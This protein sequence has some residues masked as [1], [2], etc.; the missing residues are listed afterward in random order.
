M[1]HSRGLSLRSLRWAG[2]ELECTREQKPSIPRV[3]LLRNPLPVHS[4][5]PDSVIPYRDCTSKSS[6]RYLCFGGSHVRSKG[7]ERSQDA[8]DC[9]SSSHGARPFPAKSE[10]PPLS[11]ELWTRLLNRPAFFSPA[12]GKL[13]EAP[14]KQRAQTGHRV[15]QC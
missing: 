12:K 9:A 8:L 15:W 5:H 4:Q 10:L 13:E 6:S 1:S 14:K 7:W 2:N 3:P 11:R